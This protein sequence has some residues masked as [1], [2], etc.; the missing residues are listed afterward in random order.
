MNQTDVFVFYPG[1][2]PDR[3]VNSH[4]LLNGGAGFKHIRKFRAS[5]GSQDWISFHSS[6][7]IL[8]RQLATDCLTSYC[9]AAARKE[10]FLSKR[11]A[12]L[13]L[14]YYKLFVQLPNNWLS[15]KL[16]SPTAPENLHQRQINTP[17]VLITAPTY[18]ISAVY[19]TPVFCLFTH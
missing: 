15:C 11:V 14:N 17:F 8:T 13:F 4:L 3:L 7:G 18:S 2:T 12:S 9:C 16:S 1:P 19:K 5:P 6:H 10:C